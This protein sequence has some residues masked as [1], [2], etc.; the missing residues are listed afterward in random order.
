MPL[1][2]GLVTPGRA[3]VIGAGLGGLTT[4]VL[5]AE[6][7]WDVTVLEAHA[8]PGGMMQR[9]RRGAHWFDTGF[10]IATGGAP[11]GPLRAVCDRLGLSPHL[12]W[13]D[14]EPQAHF[15]AG[16]VGEAF[17]DLP[18]G[19]QASARAL[20]A[21]DPQQAGGI[22]RFF[23]LMRGR[24]AANP[25]LC[26]IADGSPILPLPTE[27]VSVSDALSWCGINGRTGEL[28]GSLS[29]ILAMQPERCGFDL[30]AGFAGTAL[31]GSWRLAGGGDGL[32]KA[33][34][35]QLHAHGG[36]MLL[37]RRATAISHDGLN[38]STVTDA[39]GQVHPANLVVAA[40]HPD[41]VLALLGETGVRPSFKTR[42]K[43]V[44]DSAGAV[45][46]AASLS[47]PAHALGRSHHLLRL[48]D[49]GDAYVV[50][51]DRW[52]AGGPAL[53]EALVWVDP[54]E[55]AAWRSS[56]LGAR[57]EG[58]Q[59][60]KDRQRDRLLAE[61]ELRWP[62]LTA[63]ITRT[64]MASPLTFRDYIGGR[65]GGSMGLSHDLEHLGG[66]ALTARSKLRNV[67]FAG[68]SFGHPGILGT[69]I[70]GCLLAGGILDRD[71]C[72]EVFGDQS[73]E[74]VAAR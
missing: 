71:L 31:A 55:V 33:M 38:A 35:T 6:G 15:V 26:G 66:Q 69:M 61:F 18:I 68:Q 22:T 56:R 73:P 74:P 29:A 57:P 11:G 30:Y 17:L 58:Y 62:G 7:G 20:A 40:I 34:L 23:A 72:R 54:A 60:W 39:S 45:L 44:P 36:R 59:Q 65:D 27:V 48:R 32:I 50:A 4:A 13:L 46:L 10:H 63:T 43:E 24:L 70:S 21:A 37:R 12:S 67:M 64:W 5:L 2:G 1:G 16:V 41:L 47:A 19:I 8:I 25:W 51:P 52:T 49:G 3:V 28:L 14:P 9:Y 42:L 53:L